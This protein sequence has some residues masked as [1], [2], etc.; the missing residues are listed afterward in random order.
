MSLN[1]TNEKEG[2]G[3]RRGYEQNV[4]FLSDCPSGGER[5]LVFVEK[6]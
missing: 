6:Y 3:K 1:Q 5:L 4:A 2:T